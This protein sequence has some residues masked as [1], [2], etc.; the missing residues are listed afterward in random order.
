MREKKWQLGWKGWDRR[1]H[2]SARVTTCLV[3]YAN[4]TAALAAYSRLERFLRRRFSV[5]LLHHQSNET[6]GTEPYIIEA[7]TEG[8]RQVLATAYDVE[9]G[10][11]IRALNPR[12]LAIV[13]SYLK[14]EKPTFAGQLPH[15]EAR[16]SLNQS[17]TAKITTGD[18]GGDEKNP[19]LLPR[20]L[21]E[22][23]AARHKVIGKASLVYVNCEMGDYAPTIERYEIRRAYRSKGFG[24]RF[25]G[26]IEEYIGSH[27]FDRIWATDAA[28]TGSTDFWEHMSYEDIDGEGEEL[29]KSLIQ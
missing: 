1:P 20:T 7:K 6:K 22:L 2:K 26:V 19:G 27:G 8:E 18:V 12:S 21:G 29:L 16:F 23:L 3:R 28:R 17:I 25:L 14:T 10:I 5:T 9:G 4:E 11:A 13:T 15:T 24:R